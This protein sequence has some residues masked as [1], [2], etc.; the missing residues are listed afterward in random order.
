MSKLYPS[1]AP[2]EDP[3]MIITFMRL[4]WQ[5]NHLFLQLP[6]L[7]QLAEHFFNGIFN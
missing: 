2:A 5:L 4:I 1:K 6:F 3:L 7:Q